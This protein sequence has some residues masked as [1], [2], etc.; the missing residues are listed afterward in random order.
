MLSKHALKIQ[1]KK[2]GYRNDEYY[3]Q[4]ERLLT[5]VI[6]YEMFEYGNVDVLETLKNNYPE[7]S[8]INDDLIKSINDHQ[9]SETELDELIVKIITILKEKLNTEDELQAIWLC[10]TKENVEKFYSDGDEVIHEV[11]FDED[12][13][14]VSD[15]E[16]EG[17][18]I[19]SKN[20]RIE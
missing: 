11:L 12:I 15:L 16:D 2:I 8:F 6:K 1:E 13:I 3:G 14:I 9:L 18:L 17:I 20:F 19:V 7:F 4:K 10:D 5:N